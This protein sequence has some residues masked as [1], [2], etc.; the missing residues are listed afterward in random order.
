MSQKTT[1]YEIETEKQGEM[2]YE[3]EVVKSQDGRKAKKG[4]GH[5]YA[6]S[7]GEMRMDGYEWVVTIRYEYQQMNNRSK[8]NKKQMK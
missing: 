8:D 3:G 6:V 4:Y 1:K 2:V 5:K 7:M